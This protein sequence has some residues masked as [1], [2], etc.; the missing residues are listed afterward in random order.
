M[1][2]IR[3]RPK[4][5]ISA[6]G[7]T[8]TPNLPFKQIAGVER[9]YFDHSVRWGEEKRDDS[10]KKRSR[11][12]DWSQ[13]NLA[14]PNLAQQDRTSASLLLIG[15]IPADYKDILFKALN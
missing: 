8:P 3:S 13:P 1:L 2:G 4:E 11:E 10:E 9:G 6:S 5:G 7:N 12:Q 14:T 15:E